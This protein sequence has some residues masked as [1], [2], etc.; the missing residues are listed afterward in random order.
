MVTPY[1]NI[2]VSNDTRVELFGPSCTERAL[3]Q[4]L[5]WTSSNFHFP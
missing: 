5:S 3:G 4:H 1:R 2:N